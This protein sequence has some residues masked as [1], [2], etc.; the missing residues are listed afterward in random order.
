MNQIETRDNIAVIKAMI[1]KTR[2]D[3]A[4]SGVLFIALGIFCAILTLV[5]ALL[6]LFNL[7]QYTLPII[8]FMA[9]G[10]GVIGYL[11]LAKEGKRATVKSY[12][13]TLFYNVWFVCG[14]V[15]LAITFLFPNLN[16]IA[17]ENI[18]VMVAVVLGI[19]VYLS[20]IVLETVFLKLSSLV[21]WFGAL[22]MIFTSGFTSAVIMILVI[23]LGWV[24]PGLI[25]NRKYRQRNV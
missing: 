12:S 22:A 19:A 10:G 7:H 3:T 8:I 23:L 2:R 16:I 24:L 5:I 25:L 13:K 17:G 20:G 18:P 9:V 21:W 11:V 6:E 4:E 14:F 1:D 15:A